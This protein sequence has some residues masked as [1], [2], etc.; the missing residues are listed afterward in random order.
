[1]CSY[2]FKKKMNK[3]LGFTQGSSG[4]RKSQRYSRWHPKKG[5]GVLKTL[6][7]APLNQRPKQTG[8]TG[9]TPKNTTGRSKKNPACGG[10][11][12]KILQI[13]K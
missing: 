5:K 13:Q 4:T 2:F 7:G 12:N 11:L 9:G 8:I 10:L 1:M 6:T 3:F